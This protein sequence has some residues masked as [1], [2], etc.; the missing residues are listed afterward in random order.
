[1]PPAVLAALVADAI[2]EHLPPDFADRREADRA[3]QSRLAALAA[4][5]A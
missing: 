4:D 5:V 3:V 2:R 1:M